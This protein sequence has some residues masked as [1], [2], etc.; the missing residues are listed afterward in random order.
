[1]TPDLVSLVQKIAIWAIPVL[2]AITL[3]E[4]AHGWAARALGDRTAEM[5]GRMSLNPIKHIDPMGTLLVPAIMLMLGGFLFGWAKPVPIG[6]R[7]LR[8]PRRDFALV[9]LAGPMSNLVMAIGWGILAKIA[10]S[11]NPQEGV[12]LG[13]LLMARAG[14]IINLVLM[15]LNL[16][17]FP[18]LDGGRVLAGLL[19]EPQA[20]VLDR[21]E[22]Y[23]LVILIV[24]MV[25][26]ILSKI[27]I[28][29]LMLSGDALST[30]LGLQGLPLFN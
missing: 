6:I 26:G 16:L 1:M 14:I 18:P 22:P 28:W 30:V 3:H 19:P 13:V 11:M 10:I 27:M 15:V 4:V 21:I 9:A 8:N 7:N 2:F 24:L 20:R 5:L 23:G 17:P 25:T 12:W 29:P